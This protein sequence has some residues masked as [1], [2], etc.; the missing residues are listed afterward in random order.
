MEYFASIIHHDETSGIRR[1]MLL[2][3]LILQVYHSPPLNRKYK[4][5]K[6]DYGADEK[7]LERTLTSQDGRAGQETRREDP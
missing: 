6:Y 4:S 5:Q 3:S 1:T 7:A 2:K